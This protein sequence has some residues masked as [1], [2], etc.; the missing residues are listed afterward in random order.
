MHLN[1]P[2]CYEVDL[3]ALKSDFCVICLI[4]IYFLLY[5]IMTKKPLLYLMLN[6]ANETYDL[7]LSPNYALY[8]GR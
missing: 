4:L 1:E 5:F 2:W 8:K 3:I 6:S 7:K